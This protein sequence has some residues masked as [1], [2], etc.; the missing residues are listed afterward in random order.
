MSDDA[1]AFQR[2][3]TNTTVRARDRRRAAGLA[4]QAEPDAASNARYAARAM[5]VAVAVL[6]LFSSEG[7]CRFTRDLPGNAA[8]DAMVDAADRWHGLMQRLGAAQ[9]G[10][11]VRGAFSRIHD[12]RWPG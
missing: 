12:L 9:L 3:D 7:I 2:S 4:R 11:A 6:M 10:P 1:L 5:L 8:T